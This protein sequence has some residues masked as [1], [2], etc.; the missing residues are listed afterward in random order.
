MARFEDHCEESIRLFGQPYAEVHRWL[1]AFAGGP[2]YGFRHRKKRH[3]DAGI[4]EAITLF[5]EAA[6]PVARQHIITDLKD[7]GWTEADHFPRDEQD[8]V[9]MG[10]L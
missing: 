4:R 8:Y 6:G 9:K 1:D 2:E 10:L 5:G 3:H 7:E